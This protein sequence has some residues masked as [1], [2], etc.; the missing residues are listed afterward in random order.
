MAE[1][2][3]IENDVEVGEIEAVEQQVTQEQQPAPQA[4]PD[5]DIPAEFKGKSPAELARIAMHARQQMGRQANELGEVRKLADELIKSQLQ[6]KAKQEQ[7]VQPEVDFFANPQEAVRRAVES[8]PR[9]QAAEAYAM[10]VQKELAAAKFRQMHPDAQNVLA[11]PEFAE[12]V[13]GSKVRTQLFQQANAYD[14]DAADELLSTYKQLKAARKVEVP[15][16]EKAARKTTMQAA[17]VDTG[18][19]GES[20]KKIYRRT[21]LIRLKMRDP[22]RYDAMADEI[23]AAYADGRVK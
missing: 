3:D 11:D 12:Y 1:M 8:N 22:A 15:E 6:P 23:L 20:S 16:S 7:E 2:Q 5:D 4:D 21:D 9:V 17:S 14:L 19:S 13:K 18:G 10:Q